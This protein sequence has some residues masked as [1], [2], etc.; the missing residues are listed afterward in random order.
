LQSLHPPLGTVDELISNTAMKS[1]L[2]ILGYDKVYHY[3]N[4][5]SNARDHDIW[6]PLLKAKYS[7]QK[8][9]CRAQ[10]DKVIGHCA[11]VSE[12][13]EAYPEA[14]VILVEREIE[15]WLNKF[16]VVAKGFSIPGTR[17]SPFLIRD[18]QAGSMPRL[19]SG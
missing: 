18:S 7:G 12:L 1:A 10:F 4:T 19:G 14:K 3:F 9:N 13:V 16:D 2:E 11:A 6:V 5:F 17:S 8:V 15:A